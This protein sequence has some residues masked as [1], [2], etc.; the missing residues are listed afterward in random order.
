[1]VEGGVL[2][3]KARLADRQPSGILL[4]CGGRPGTGRVPPP[5]I[6]GGITGLQVY[7]AHVPSQ[8]LKV[9]VCRGQT[10]ATPLADRVQR[11]SPEGAAAPQASPA[12]HYPP[13]GH[14]NNT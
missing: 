6:A 12:P 2:Q 9:Q 3:Q 7:S 10:H 8:H 14:D 11:S 13:L 1:M 5:G 4:C